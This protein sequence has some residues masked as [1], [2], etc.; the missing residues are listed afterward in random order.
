[1]THKVVQEIDLTT[2]EQNYAASVVKYG[3]FQTLDELTR[4][5]KLFEV[6]V[7]EKKQIERNRVGL[8]ALIKK[9]IIGNNAVLIN[10]A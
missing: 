7:S 6:I 3:E 1:L 2:S 10:F 8:G 9:H 5:V 4:T